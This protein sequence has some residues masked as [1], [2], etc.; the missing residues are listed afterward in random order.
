MI[1]DAIRFWHTARWLQ[2]VQVWGK[3][4]R[5][6][7]RPRPDLR[8]APSR[9]QAQHGSWRA[10]AR[11]PSMT[12]HSTLRFLSVE[13]E[14]ADRRDWNRCAWSKL[15]LYNLHYFNDLVANEAP[16]RA[17]W[18]NALLERWISENPPGYGNGWE[19]YPTSLRIVN[20]LKWAL[21]GNSLSSNIT[22]SLAVQVRW[23]RRRLEFHLLGNHLWS[24]AKA[25]LFAGAFFSGT[26]A[27][28]WRAQG[29]KILR[30]QLTE[31]ILPDGGHFER[32]AM[33]HAIMLEDLLDLM[34]LAQRLPSAFD[35]QDIEAW[36]SKSRAMMHWL[37]AMTHPDGGIAFFNDTALDTAPSA[38]VLSAYA[39]AL[40]LLVDD[41]AQLDGCTALPA[42]GY[43]RLQLGQ[44]VVIADAGE[45]GPDHLPGHAHA[46]T[47]SFELSL[48]GE[49]LLVNGGTSTYEPG[50]A[51]LRDRGTGAHNTIMVDGHDSSE[52][53][54][55]F[56]VARRAHPL[57]VKSGRDKKC[58]WL[59]AA[60]DGYRRLPGKVVHRRHWQLS[61]RRLDIEDMLYGDWHGAT[62]YLHLHPDFS[63]AMNG[64]HITLLGRSNR[65]DMTIQGGH[66]SIVADTWYPTFGQSVPSMTIQIAINQPRSGVTI[67]W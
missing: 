19:P 13:R 42:S 15:W 54:G 9:A 8:P 46:D 41:D 16:A 23:L 31:Q 53:W 11:K 58:A 33:Y 10:C 61:E 40:G 12:G 63:A 26:E 48:N 4:W 49:R 38:S 50:I 34:Q 29:M 22:H 56:R 30:R 62:S 39:H 44:A 32:S 28:S 64:S 5:T 45:I 65:V 36:G 3:I 52:V 60:H 43:W 25:L 1:E 27:A 17:H 57:A 20:C 14:L 2:P 6:I 21:G 59:E 18:H 51:R 35:T 55:S 24:N 37:R 7:N 66:G 67:T 47:L